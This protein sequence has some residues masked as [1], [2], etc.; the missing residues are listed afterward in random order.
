MD[1][2]KA[3]IVDDEALARV[4]IRQALDSYENWQVVG[5]LHNGKELS[6]MIK[7]T[8]P[9]VVFL[10][11]QMP[12]TSGIELAAQLMNEE[13]CPQ[14]VF[15]TAYD[16]YAVN[17]FELCAFDYL[18]KPF[19]D[20]RFMKTIKRLE[21]NLIATKDHRYIKAWQKKQFSSE[22]NLDKILIRSIGSIRIIAVEDIYSFHSCGN[23]VE[24][25]HI[26]GMHL[27]RISLSFLET[28]LDSVQF[29][30]VHRSAIVRLS[31]IKEIKVL[32]DNSH[33]LVLSNGIEVKISVAYKNKVF[34]RLGL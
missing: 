30:R 8:E 25:H 27:H 32:D 19:D 18:L 34:D 31:E 11:I 15:V 6:T 26:E 16:E 10:D 14:I 22:Q 17:A 28:K 21:S 29:C 9:T 1:K 33:Q 4:N 2:F 23:Y 3:L 24:V 7:Q 5:E 12:S 13:N 20:E